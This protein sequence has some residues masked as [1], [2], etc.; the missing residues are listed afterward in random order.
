MSSWLDRIYPKVAA[1]LE[2]NTRQRCFDSYE[3][4]WD[5]ERGNIEEFGLLKTSYDFKEA[6]KH[7]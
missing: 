3:V 5:E 7:Q 4:F 6:N 2:A 1:A